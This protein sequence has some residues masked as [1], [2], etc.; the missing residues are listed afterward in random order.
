[1]LLV[2]GFFCWL[3][4]FSLSI[5]LENFRAVNFAA[6]FS[7]SIVVAQ[8]LGHK[9]EITS[10]YEFKLKGHAIFLAQTGSPLEFPLDREHQAYFVALILIVVSLGFLFYDNLKDDGT[11]GYEVKQ[12]LCCNCKEEESGRLKGEQAP[13]L[14]H[15]CPMKSP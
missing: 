12:D 7:I 8:F 3:T 15:K 14:V 11:E 2:D 1:M 5:S 13:L 6:F 9:F 10:T 4:Q